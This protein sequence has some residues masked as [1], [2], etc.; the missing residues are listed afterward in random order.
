MCARKKSEVF[1]QRVQSVFG[2]TLKPAQG[3][4]CDLSSEGKEVKFVACN[5]WA[6]NNLGNRKI[7]R[8]YINKCFN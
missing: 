6:Q 4:I 8:P 1:L 7:K 2:N 5:S 3:K